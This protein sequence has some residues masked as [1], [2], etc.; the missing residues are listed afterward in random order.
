MKTRYLLRKLPSSADHRIL[1]FAFADLSTYHRLQAEI[2]Q[3]ENERP[4][5]SDV[6]ARRKLNAAQLAARIVQF[7]FNIDAGELMYPLPG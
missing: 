3:L 5:Q 6:L 4:V 2:R 1:A 7:D